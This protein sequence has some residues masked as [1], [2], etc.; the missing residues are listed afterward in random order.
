[1]EEWKD[2][3]LGQLVELKNG[4][5]FKSSEFLE[6]GVPVIKIKNVKPNRIL[7][8]D[9]SYV[10]QESSLNKKCFDI[11]PSDILITMTGNRKDGGA[12]SWVGKVALFNQRGRFLLNQ[13]VSAIRV[14]DHSLV[15]FI[16]LSYLLSGW[17]AQLYFVN[18]SNSSGGQAN[19]SP[20]IVY[21][22][23][24]T[25]PP[26]SI[27]QKIASILKAIDNKIEV[28]KRINDNFVLESFIEFLLIWTLVSL[29]NDNLEKQA[30]AL[31]KSWFVDFEPFQ[32]GEFVGSELGMIPKGWLVGTLG[33]I[34]EISKKTRNPQKLPQ[35]TFIHF[36][37]PAFDD[38]MNP[39]NQLGK[40]IKSNKFVIEN[41]MT[42]FS[43]LN[44]RIKR[45]WYLDNLGINSICSTEFVPYK[46]KDESQSF[47]LYELINNQCF[48]DYVMS[49]VNGATGS[50]QRF[51]P[52]ESLNYKIAYNVEFVMKYCE[53][54]AP[55]VN[56][57]LKKR[58]ES[59]R[60]THLR[61]TLLPRL[62]SGELKVNDVT[63]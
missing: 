55:M 36:S 46:A 14:K 54:V 13:R 21:N 19:I 28:N 41:K 62:M 51:H 26:L 32:E 23:T 8:E 11:F 24:V 30:Q 58:D 33:D 57:I 59:R 39:E 50:H 25:L 27:Q 15:D 38:G 43:K 42:L 56:Q 61:D 6:K 9:L 16:F 49:M 2:Y 12:D 7:L 10:S 52:E 35:T 17:D 44:P 53:V 29:I 47:F 3:N 1:M 63:I 34:A 40:E 31:F 4:V 18:H 22:Y 45:I 48:Y 37:I 5:A 60:L 20:D